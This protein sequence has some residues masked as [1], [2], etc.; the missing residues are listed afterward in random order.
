MNK[1]FKEYV[2]MRDKQ[3]LAENTNRTGDSVL[4]PPL[5]IIGQ[6]PTAY[7]MPVHSTAGLKHEEKVAKGKWK[8]Y[9]LACR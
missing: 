8:N 3:A 1:T 2:V 7:M 9:E 5:Y 6:Y 4:Y